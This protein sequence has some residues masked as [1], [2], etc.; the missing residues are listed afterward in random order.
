LSALSSSGGL[1]RQASDID[2]RAK[3]ILRV[4]E[5]LNIT[6]AKATGQP[7]E[8][9]ERDV[10]RGRNPGTRRAPEY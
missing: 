2:A 7:A 9:I 4:R 1:I 3:K 8:R 6:L 10:D 5:A